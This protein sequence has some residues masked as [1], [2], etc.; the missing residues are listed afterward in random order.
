M[1]HFLHPI[2]VLIK[3]LLLYKILD[4]NE[5]NPYGNQMFSQN[6]PFLL[7]WLSY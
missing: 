3:P 6:S 1:Q 2:T 7:K 5:T 4:Y